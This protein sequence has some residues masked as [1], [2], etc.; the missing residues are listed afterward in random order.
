MQYI[1]EAIGTQ[2]Q[3]DFDLTLSEVRSAQLLAKIKDRIEVFDK[4][5]SRFRSDSIVTKMSQKAGQ[6]SLPDDAEPL[7][8]L[9]KKLYDSTNGLFTPLIGQLLVESGYD[10]KYSLSK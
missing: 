8:S 6:Y 4:N 7:F 2:W 9:Y 1:F 5:Y 10:E 3:I